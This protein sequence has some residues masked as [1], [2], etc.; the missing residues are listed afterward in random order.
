MLSSGCDKNDTISNPEV[1]DLMGKWNLTRY[2]YSIGGPPI[3]EDVSE[4]EMLQF[5]GDNTFN[6]DN[7]Q[8]TRTGN[9]EIKNDSL[10]RTY[11]DDPENIEYISNMELKRNKLVLIPISPSRCIEGCAWEYT[12]AE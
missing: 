3:W 2:Q 7:R 9:Y 10:I 6:S 11:S 8:N 4:G 5:F 1:S 12:K